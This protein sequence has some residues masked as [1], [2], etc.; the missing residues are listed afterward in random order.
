MNWARMMINNLNF[1]CTKYYTASRKLFYAI[2][3]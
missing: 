3:R 2:M 1:V